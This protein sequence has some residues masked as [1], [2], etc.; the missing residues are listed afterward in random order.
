MVFAKPSKPLIVVVLS[1]V[2]WLKTVTNQLMSNWLKLS[3]MNTKFLLS[4]YFRN[5]IPL[6][7]FLN[8]SLTITNCIFSFFLSFFQRFPITRNS[9]K[10]LD[11]AKSIV[12]ET[13]VKLLHVHVLPSLTMVKNLK[14]LMSFNNIS[15]LVK[16][17]L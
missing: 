3:A 10:W 2:F 1:C 5:F 9:E 11:Y 12:K 14:L 4:K 17:N 15:K 7:S 8:F 16:R 6:K 13:H